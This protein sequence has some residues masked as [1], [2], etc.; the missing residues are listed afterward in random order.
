MREY[1]FLNNN[2]DKYR[3][4]I[5]GTRKKKYERLYTQ[6]QRL[7]DEVL[8]KEHPQKS[9]TY[10]GIGVVNLS[11]MY[12]LTQEER[13]LEKAKEFLFAAV[14]YEK[15]GNAHLV[16]VDLSASWIMFGMSV[17]YDWLKD[18]LTEEEC[19]LIKDKLILQSKIMYDYKVE[20]HGKGWS[21]N[22]Y[23]NHNWINMTGLAAA[24][25]VL[26]DEYEFAKE[27]IEISKENFDRVYSYLSGDGSN[28]EG[29]VYWHYGVIWLFIYADMVKK[30]GGK[31]YFATSK[32]LENTFFYKLYQTTPNLEENANFGDC[33]DRRSGHCPAIYYKTASEYHNGYAQFLGD[34]VLDNFLY[35]EHCNSKLKPGIISEGFFEYIWYNPEIESKNLSELPLHRHFEDLGLISIRDS[36][37]RDGL[38]FSL[39]CG[40]PGGEKQWKKLWELYNEENI[41]AFSLS[42]NHPDNNSF[43]LNKN[44]TYF[45]I[46]DGYNRNIKAID[47][48]TIIVDNETCEVD[49][50]NDVLVSSAFKL[51]EAGY[52][53]EKELTG[54]IKNFYV[55]NDFITFT[56]DN[57]GY[58]KKSLNIIK[59]ERTV[60]YSN[61]KFIIMIDKI[62]SDNKHEYSYILNSDKHPVIN[63]N[64]L[65]YDYPLEKMFLYPVLPK[66]KNIDMVSN[67]IKAVMTTQEPDKFVIN[68]MKTLKISTADKVKKAYFVN[69]I[70]FEKIEIVEVETEDYI[71]ISVE[72]YNE[73]YRYNKKFSIVEKR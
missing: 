44:N 10:I 48:N 39:K 59:S 45:A 5:K 36:W 1:I 38:F 53:P 51:L 60:I 68:K 40:A 37:E 58:Y 47:H 27:F 35:K 67:T 50:V 66:D 4:D 54:R 28:Y 62:I 24:G 12:L 11:F 31:D 56:G 22:Y 23:Q 69:I 13:Y 70:A 52:N 43:I 57:K 18:D 21:T 16:N 55:E 3:K 32:F 6:C 26:K 42:H 9:T 71:E 19:K 41:N 25:Y 49:N 64:Y 73:I 30:Q 2:I 7:C 72:K 15:W 14:G 8:P 65:L 61:S 29:V 20:N 34:Y 63:E 46:D 33:H 17:A